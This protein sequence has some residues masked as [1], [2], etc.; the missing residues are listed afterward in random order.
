M[1]SIAVPKEISERILKFDVIVLMFEPT[2]ILVKWEFLG[3]INPV[4]WNLTIL[5]GD[6]QSGLRP[7]Q[8]KPISGV[9]FPEY[10]DYGTFQRDNHRHLYYQI[11]ADN[12]KD[13]RRVVSEIKTWHGDLDLEAIYVIEEHEFLFQDATGLPS[14][15]FVRMR[16]GVRCTECW[17]TIAEKRKYAN[18]SGCNGTGFLKGYH[19]PIPTWVD[20]SPDPKLKIIEQWGARQPNEIDVFMT[21]WPRI[22]PDD[23]IAQAVSGKRYRVI[24]V[25]ESE[26]RGVPM[27]QLARCEL[28]P[29]TDPAYGLDLDEGQVRA[30]NDKLNEIK[31]LRKF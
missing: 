11:I 30:L 18:C 22:L 25:T 9:A 21:S 28:I 7:I 8:Q 17:D 10:V 19:D 16:D 13:S 29:K 5:R 15:I 1:D 26:V 4:D 14:F 20:Y 24:R 31:A 6:N 3:G 12:K 23:M 2:K 27:L